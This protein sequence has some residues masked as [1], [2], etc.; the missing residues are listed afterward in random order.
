MRQARKLLAELFMGRGVEP[1]LAQ[2]LARLALDAAVAAEL[3]PPARAE[4]WE[5]E[6]QVYSMRG[7]GVALR[8]IQEGFCMSR[9]QIYSAVRRHGK[10]RRA[11][12]RQ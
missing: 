10:R 1:L 8:D 9:S 3:V 12:L 6:A 11:A 4:S 7:Q 5:R 2:A